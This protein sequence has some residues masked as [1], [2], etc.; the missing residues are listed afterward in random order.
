METVDIKTIAYIIIAL[1]WFLFSSFQK[2]QKKAKE[3]DVMPPLKEREIKEIITDRVGPQR[4][5]VKKESLGFV[6]ENESQLSQKKKTEIALP[7]ATESTLPNEYDNLL[8]DFDP[9]KMVLYSEIFNRK[10]Y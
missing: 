7:T 8:E 6:K 9:K 5:K 3:K 10:E 2:A 1:L 4:K